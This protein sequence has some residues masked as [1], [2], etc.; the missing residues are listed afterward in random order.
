MTTANAITNENGHV[1]NMHFTVGTAGHGANKNPIDEIT[2]HLVPRHKLGSLT[3]KA[4]YK[5]LVLLMRGFN[6]I[7]IKKPIAF[8]SDT[9]CPDKWEKKQWRPKFVAI[10][11]GYKG[12]KV[13]IVSGNSIYRIGLYKTSWEYFRS[14]G[15]VDKIIKSAD[16]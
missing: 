6:L 3:G 5:K 11:F 13:R 1:L 7:G 12:Y 8:Y 2:F 4:Q 16:K 15:F 14:F 10:E 9:K